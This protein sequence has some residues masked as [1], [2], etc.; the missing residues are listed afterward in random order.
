MQRKIDEV[1][2]SSADLMLKLEDKLNRE[3]K[4]LE[5]LGNQKSMI[6]CHCIGRIKLL[7][8]ELN[9]LYGIYGRKM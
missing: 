1:G 7:L 9:T 8:K 5:S 6:S 4:F 2:L 3:R